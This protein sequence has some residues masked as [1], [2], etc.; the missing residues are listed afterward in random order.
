MHIK[1][2]ELIK[3][4]LTFH[5]SFIENAYNDLKKDEVDALNEYLQFCVK[6]ELSIEYL[7]ECYSCV[8]EDTMLA[9][10]H[11]KRTGKYQYS[12]FDEVRKIVYDNPTYMDKY[13]HGLAITSFI[14]PN[15][16]KILDFFLEVLPAGNG[17]NYLEV[18][19]G[20]GYFFL[21]AL[22]RTQYDKFYAIDVS[23]KSIELTAT[24]CRELE[25]DNFGKTEYILGDFLHS[26]VRDCDKFDIV[27]MGEVLEHIENPQL[28]LRR[29][30]ELCKEDGF[31]F[32]TTCVNSPAIDHISLFSTTDEID[33]IIRDSGFRILRSLHA[34]YVGKSLEESRELKLPINVAY[35]LQRS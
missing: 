20:H 19:P 32:V 35:L 9:Q 7:A 12:S 16:R 15:H 5:S 8:V 14:W 27:V 28:F 17:G 34:P 13:M 4:Q 23:Q 22:R 33:C 24:L 1:L 6:S 29:L 3:Q 2:K 26:T 31:A 30:R 18:G 21:N 11:F 25:P 10:I